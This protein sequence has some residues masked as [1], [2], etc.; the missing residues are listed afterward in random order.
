MPKKYFYTTLGSVWQIPDIMRVICC[1]QIF[2]ICRAWTKESSHEKL[3]AGYYGRK[4]HGHRMPKNIF[5]L[6]G[7]SVWPI[8]EI[9]RVICC[10]ENFR[11]CRAWT[12]MSSHD[13]REVCYKW[14]KGH[15]HRMPKN[16]SALIRISVWP[17]PEIMRVICCSQIFSI[18]KAWTRKSSI[19]EWVICYLGERGCSQ[20]FLETFLH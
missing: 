10:G 3:V 14:G 11:I 16:I 7:C 1:G 8:P 6:I 4:S 9:M 5:A 15:G 20:N 18:C 19:N 12:R 13:E 17:L 2:S